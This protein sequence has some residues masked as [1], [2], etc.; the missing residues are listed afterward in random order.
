MFVL[1]YYT[2]IILQVETRADSLSVS[3]MRSV[4]CTS[5]Q[6]SPTALTAAEVTRV[7]LTAVCWKK[8]S[9]LTHL[10]PDNEPASVRHFSLFLCV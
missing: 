2:L 3:Q 10:A 5:P 1:H 4:L 6:M 8:S 9:V 7:V